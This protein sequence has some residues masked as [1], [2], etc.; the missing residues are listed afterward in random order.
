MPQ[1]AAT[2]F[3]LAMPKRKSEGG[4]S[5]LQRTNQLWKIYVFGGALALG[6]AATLLQGFLY[7][8][9]GKELAMKIGVAGMALI[10]G[11]FFWAGLNIRCPQCQ[12]KIFYY[13]L[14][15]KGFLAWFAWLLQEEDC[16]Q[17]GPAEAPRT[18]GIRRKAKG[19]KRP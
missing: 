13:A 12:L 10:I 7:E 9:L 17:C 5:L 6:C 18:G 11:S 3:C 8:P 2:M 15:H 19:L 1:L 16:P 14:K 4:V